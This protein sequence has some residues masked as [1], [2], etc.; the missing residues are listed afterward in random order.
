M[1]PT[2]TFL[3]MLQ[4]IEAKMTDNAGSNANNRSDIDV[5]A[6]VNRAAVAF[7]RSQRLLDSWQATA[8]K[9]SRPMITGTDAARNETDDELIAYPDLFGLGAVAN[10]PALSNGRPHPSD[11]DQLKRRLLGRKA[12][13]SSTIENSAEVQDLGAFSKTS[14]ITQRPR[15]RLQHSSLDPEDDEH[16]AGR[17]ASFP[18]KKKRKMAAENDLET[19]QDQT[20]N[21]HIERR[22]DINHAVAT[23]VESNPP[24]EPIDRPERKTTTYLDELLAKRETKKLKKQKK[25]EGNQIKT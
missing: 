4:F 23:H 1:F 8:A 17:T 7:A 10:L 24:I 12:S 2:R 13:D 15:S 20:S 14:K 21:D 22:A 9:K 25:K 11:L 18:S 5:D 6:I 16:D 19:V 3:D